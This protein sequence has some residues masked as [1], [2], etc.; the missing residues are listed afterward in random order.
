MQRTEIK[1]NPDPVSDN[2][3]H[4]YMTCTVPLPY[5]K[6]SFENLYQDYQVFDCKVPIYTRN[7]F[8]EMLTD[9]GFMVEEINGDKYICGLWLRVCSTRKDLIYAK[10][11]S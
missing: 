10:K 5:R 6:I 1:C 8:E 2:F 4:W 9:S 3:L 7:V 11:E